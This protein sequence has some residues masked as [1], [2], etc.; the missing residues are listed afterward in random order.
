MSNSSNKKKKKS[1]KN[2]SSNKKK[3]ILSEP[4]SRTKKNAYLYEK[5]DLSI[6][7]QQKFN[8]DDD[9]VEDELD[10]SFLEKPKRKVNK[11]I[12]IEKKVYP[13][14]TI[15]LLIILLILC[16]GLI[17]Y[18]GYKNNHKSQTVSKKVVPENIVFLGDSITDFYDLDKYYPN[19]FVVNSGIS[20]NT[21]DD[22]LEDMKNRVYCYNPSKVFLLIGT[23]DLE[24][25]TS[26]D[27]IVN[28][29]I[30]ITKQ[31]KK[32]RKNTKIYIES[33]YPVNHDIG[34]NMAGKRDNNDIKEINKKL[35]KYCQENKFTYINL[36]SVL[37]DDS[38]NLSI[39]VTDD[40]LHLN[41]KGYDLLTDYLDNY[42]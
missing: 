36:Y 26:I 32:N 27:N 24:L 20:G 33:I 15:T 18:L 12:I 25:G 41:E 39:D 38:D 9:L 11:K 30:K 2:K 37:K 35:K 31:I 40:G 19:N 23:N 8:F 34:N 10:T 6:T 13:V 14:K 42:L 4:K 17:I 28:N 7:K 21:T 3:P 29:I 5:E 16:F 22:I 1:S